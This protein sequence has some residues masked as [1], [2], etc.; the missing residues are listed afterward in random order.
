MANR[1]SRA[2]VLVP[3]ALI[4]AAL[5]VWF[6]PSLTSGEKT[7]D[8]KNKSN[9][10]ASQ[11]LVVDYS[12]VDTQECVRLVQKY[13][14]YARVTTLKVDKTKV[15]T[16]LF[17]NGS[18]R[19]VSGEPKPNRLQALYVNVPLNPQTMEAKRAVT[20]HDPA[21]AATTLNG[22]GRQRVGNHTIAQL[23]P[24]M[25]AQGDPRAIQAWAQRCTDGNVKMHLACAK[26]MAATA[27]LLGI[28]HEE[29]VHKANSLW[30]Y[31]LAAVVLHRV[32]PFRLAATQE[33]NA[34]FLVASVT[35]KTTGCVLR[36]G[37]N[38]GTN[39]PNGGDQRLAGLAC[40]TPP[41]KVPPTGSRPPGTSKPPTRTTTPPRRTTCFCVD[42]TQVRQAVPTPAKGRAVPDEPASQPT[43]PLSTDNPPTP[44]KSGHNGGSTSNPAVTGTPT[45]VDTGK[46]GS[47]G[48]PS[49]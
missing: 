41:V 49:R 13:Y 25:E 38:V 32:P 21:D 7:A 30:N 48:D 6:V 11:L 28:F 9:P 4:V 10:T 22:L 12:R 24:W 35:S 5:A 8:S 42:K 3:I 31:E 40:K 26:T 44:R 1:P 36:I 39:T 43:R 29:G 17:D 2:W 34:Y 15:T 14:G 18:M 20:C 37:F 47:V 16:V 45:V 27:M 19:P 23:N 33:H 46:Y